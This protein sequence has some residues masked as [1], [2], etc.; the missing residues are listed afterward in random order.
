M[1]PFLHFSHR[2]DDNSTLYETLYHYSFRCIDF[3]FLTF[4]EIYIR[5][6]HLS[7]PCKLSHLVHISFLITK[8]SIL[9]DLFLV[10]WSHLIL[11]VLILK[12]NITHNRISEISKDFIPLNNSFPTLKSFL[13]ILIQSRKLDL[14]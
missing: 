4:A 7:N 5:K 12:C 13:F 14:D 10:S 2:I 1:S 3:S 8:R 6:Y 9:I 11:L